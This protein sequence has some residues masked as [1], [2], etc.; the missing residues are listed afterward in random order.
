MPSEDTILEQAEDW[1]RRGNEAFQKSQSDE[2]IQAY[3]QGLVQ[4]DRAVPPP[5]ALKTA[6]LSNRAACYL[7]KMSLQAC[8]DDCTKA[9]ELLQETSSEEPKLRSKLLFRRAK[10]SFLK[11]NTPGIDLGNSALNDLLQGA[12]KDLLALLS[13]DAKNKEASA[14]LQSIRAQHAIVKKSFTPLSKTL[15]QVKE[16]EDNDKE[17]IHKLKVLGG[18]LDSDPSSASMEL[19]RLGGV[20]YLLN[21]AHKDKSNA[22]QEARTVALNCISCAGGHP[23]FVRKYLKDVQTQIASI[24]KTDEFTDVVVCGLSVLV[25]CVLHLDRDDANKPVVQTSDIND[26]ALLDACIAVLNASESEANVAVRG[27]MENLSALTCGVDRPMLVRTAIAGDVTNT[28][29]LDSI[30]APVSKAEI[31]MMTAKELATHRQRQKDLKD[32]DIKWS[33]QRAKLFVDK[34]GLKAILKCAAKIS[35]HFLRREMTV[36]IGKIMTALDS[37]EDVKKLVKPFLMAQRDDEFDSNEMCTIEEIH[38]DDEDEKQGGVEE[39]EEVESL[40]SMMERAELTVSLL[41]SMKEVGAWAICTAWMLSDKEL[42]RMVDSEEDR[43]MAIASEVLS[44]A[45]SVPESR[46]MVTMMMDAGSMEKLLMHDDRDIRSGAAAA[47]AKLGLAGRD[48]DKADEGDVMGMLQAA[49]DLLEDESGQFE[50]SQTKDN[51]VA[52]LTKSFGTTSLERGVEMI[53]YLVSQTI[54]KEEICGGFKAESDS[55]YTTLECLVKISEMSKAG[56]S[57]SGYGLAAIFNHLAVTPSTLKKEHFADKELSAEEYDQLQTMAKTDEEKK[58]FEAIKEDDTDELCNERIRVMAKT[59]VPRALVQLMDGASDKTLEQ[60]VVALN[61]MAVEPG[62]RGSMIQ[63]GALTACIKVDHDSNPTDLMKTIIRNAR[64]CIAKMLVTMNP[65]HLTS[66]QCMGSIKPLIQLTR[67][68]EASDLQQ[69]EALMAL[70][71]IGASGDEKKSKIVAE[72][73]IASLHYAMFSQHHLIRKASTEAMCNLVGNAKFTEH[74]KDPEH[75]K[76]WLAFSADYEEHYECARAA[77]GCLAMATQDPDIAN[78]LVKLP[79]FKIHIDELLQCGALELMHRVLAI[80]LNLVSH[81]GDCKAAVLSNGFSDFCLQYV[82]SYH[83]GAK[84]EDLGFPEEQ[85]HLFP[86]TLDLAKKVAAMS[87]A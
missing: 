63:Q 31:N 79:K 86:V 69:F 64:H 27:V 39:E 6:L 62:A 66:A 80:L 18:L 55:Q 32:R 70:T 38:N 44:A 73:G 29:V 22:S 74:L 16:N 75:L 24:V 9:I 82:D 67:D 71:N 43:P 45:A 14:L 3:S 52:S 61:R 4:A 83:D 54:I 11:V 2:A 1:K 40:Q 23:P 81:G 57:L 30:P 72:S 46:H 60:I 37:E 36:A 33:K 7:K 49:A 53:T 35:D 77:S 8:I 65:S 13:F 15:D 48:R 19:G 59:N 68:V 76:L 85:K 47:V 50:A 12:A 10:A 58:M 21:L 56:A 34:Q 42:V 87:D 51:A 5:V 17:Q 41:L 25:K 78:A 26:N 28:G 20:A 84:L